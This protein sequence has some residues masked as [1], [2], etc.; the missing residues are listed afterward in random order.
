MN[1][2]CYTG[3]GFIPPKGCNDTIGQL[4]QY[5]NLGVAKGM[6]QHAPLVV[7]GVFGPQTKAGLDALLPGWTGQMDVA[8]LRQ[9]KAKV[10]GSPDS[11]DFSCTQPYTPDTPPLPPDPNKVDLAPT[12]LT[13]APFST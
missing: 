6:W 13:G 11:R 8:A 3:L 12:S 7:D 4:Q 2:V 9:L 5:I 10:G 1:C